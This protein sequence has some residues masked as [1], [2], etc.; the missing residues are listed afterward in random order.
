MRWPGRTLIAGLD[1]VARAVARALDAV[2]APYLALV[3][4][5]ERF[6]RA[7]C[8]GFIVS[9]GNGNRLDLLD[10]T[11]AGTA[12]AIVMGP[13]DSA[14]ADPLLTALRRR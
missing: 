7:R 11:G 2:K 8:D 9:Y 12:R 3:D 14:E 4:D 1:N 13:D 10:A 6:A 5:P